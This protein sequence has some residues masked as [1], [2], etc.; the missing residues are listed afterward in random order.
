VRPQGIVGAL[1]AIAVGAVLAYAV[2]YTAVGINIHL[3]GGIIMVVG[4]VAL[5]VF[6][7]WAV[8]DARRR[9]R[10]ERRRVM[11]VQPTPVV[12]QRYAQSAPQA[13][14]PVAP[15]TGMPAG[16]LVSERRAEQ[17]VIAP[18]LYRTTETE[19]QQ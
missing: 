17:V 15:A 8:A 19:R 10:A 12:E 16:Y 6:V 13:V 18:D 9:G 3:V 14:V 2:N 5:V 1:F 11:V 7:G 4:L